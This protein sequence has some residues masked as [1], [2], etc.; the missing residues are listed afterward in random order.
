M[1]SFFLRY[2]LFFNR[3]LTEYILQVLK[4]V[5]RRKEV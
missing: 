3:Q 1:L 5:N 2:K 4:K